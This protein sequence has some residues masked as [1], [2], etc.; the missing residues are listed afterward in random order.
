MDNYSVDRAAGDQYQETFPHIVDVARNSRAFLARAIRFLARE[1]GIRQVL[2]IGTDTD[3][4]FRQAQQGYDAR[5]ADAYRLRGPEQIAAFFAGLELVE[6]GVVSL[7][8]L[9]D[10][11]PAAGSR[12]PAGRRSR[13]RDRCSV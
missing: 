1:A 2:D 10:F 11:S 13:G 5:G 9:P 3:T 12:R 6:P 8:I 7:P 4:A